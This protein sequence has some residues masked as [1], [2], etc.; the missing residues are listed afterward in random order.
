MGNRSALFNLVITGSLLLAVATPTLAAPAFQEVRQVLDSAIADHAFPG[1]TFAVGTDEQVLWSGALGYQTYESQA[2]IAP[3]SLYDLASITKIVGTTAVVMRLVDQGKLAIEQPIANYLPEFFDQAPT[4]EER[5]KREAV[6]IAHLLTHTS[7]L[8]AWKPLYKSASGYQ[9]TLQAIF[10]TKLEAPVGARYRYSDLGLIL[11]G[12]LAARAGGKPLAD[13]ERD[14]IFKPLGMKSTLRNPSAK[15]KNRCVPTE[16]VEKGQPPIQGVVHDENA[17]F[18]DGITGHAGLFSTA[19][20]MA[21]FAAEM[22]RALDGKSN[23]FSL[24]TVSLFTQRHPVAEKDSNRGLGWQMASG[25]N[26]AGSILSSN[27]FGHTGFTGTSIWIDPERKLYV[28]LL[29]NRVYPTRNNSKLSAV[30]RDFADAVAQA[31]DGK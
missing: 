17:R 20:D 27:S 18:A 25:G 21:K 15:L 10:A 2:P 6:T 19:E 28:I 13:L 12:E 23:L 24:Q 3:D 9:E 16:I 4:P 22:L 8:P 11:L 30:R 29:T 31:V 26:S 5:T 7:G 14:L 1:C